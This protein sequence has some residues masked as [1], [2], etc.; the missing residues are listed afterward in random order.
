MSCSVDY[1]DVHIIIIIVEEFYEII[2][3]PYWSTDCIIIHVHMYMYILYKCEYDTRPEPTMFA[4]VADYKYTARM[5]YN[6]MCI[7]TWCHLPDVYPS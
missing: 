5:R 6:Y 2:S 3:I 4:S 7:C 1:N